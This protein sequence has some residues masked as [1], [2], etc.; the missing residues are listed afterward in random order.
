MTTVG[1]VGC[2]NWG[3]HILR[4]LLTLGCETIVADIDASARGRALDRGA[5]AVFA[6][7]SDLP[8]CDGYVVA[9]PIPDLAKV[10]SSL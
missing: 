1:L 6:E 3:K 2:G 10:S 7:A 4:D 8:A 5:S 9:V